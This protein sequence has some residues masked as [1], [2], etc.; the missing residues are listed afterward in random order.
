VVTAM[1]A[2]ATDF[3]V[4]PIGAE[5][6]QVSLRNALAASALED[7]L[8]RIASPTFS[9]PAADDGRPVGRR[10]EEVSHVRR[11]EWIADFRNAQ[12]PRP[13]ARAASN[14]EN[15]RAALVGWSAFRY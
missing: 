3:V 2:G 5:R 9:M 4:K 14:V 8:A 10:C 13:A 15:K 11:G 7:E 6:L 12:C 1:R